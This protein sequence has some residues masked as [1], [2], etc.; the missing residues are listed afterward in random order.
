MTNAA[1]A[2]PPNPS[3]PRGSSLATGVYLNQSVETTDLYPIL[4]V[5]LIPR[6]SA[7]ESN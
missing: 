4:K 5:S 1:L 3:C 7:V 6:C 2:Q